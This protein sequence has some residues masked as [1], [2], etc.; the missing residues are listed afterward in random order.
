M[1][2]ARQRVRVGIHK[3]VERAF[4]EVCA[5]CQPTCCPLAGYYLAGHD[6]GES[7]EDRQAALAV[8]RQDVPAGKLRCV[9]GVGGPQDILDCVATGFDV[10]ESRYASALT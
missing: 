5:A 1:W 10:M 4:D 6:V 2:H 3:P 9:S 8:I 7:P